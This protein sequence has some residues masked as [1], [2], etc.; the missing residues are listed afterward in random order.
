MADQFLKFSSRADLQ[1]LVDEGLEESLTLDYKDSRALTRDGKGPDEMCKDVSALANSAGGQLIYGIQEDKKRGKPKAMDA[2]VED[3]KVTREW[4]EQVLTS[5]VQ[6]RMIGV[7]IDRI[8]LSPDKYAYVVTV[9]PTNIGPHQAPD[10]KYYRRFDLQSVPMED[11]EIRD[12]QK[13]T[14]TPHLVVTPKLGSLI[15]QPD[16][17]AYPLLRIS[18]AMQNLGREPAY[19]SLVTIGVSGELDFH[20][21]AGFD[22]IGTEHT[23]DGHT[24]HFARLQVGI[25]RFFP[26]FK[27]AT[28]PLTPDET[29]RF[30]LLSQIPNDEML[31][32]ILVQTMG[33]ESTQDWVIRKRGESLTLVGPHTPDFVST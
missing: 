9:P 31:L 2:G 4:I 23:P 8:E 20:G 14:T 28:F 6:P 30:R 3:P 27:G 29:P 15:K 33:F 21:L 10:K 13:R 1:R 32:R 25:P 17:G 22:A 24:L 11:Y 5:R 12:V 18:F 19:Y 7:R 16:L 26:I